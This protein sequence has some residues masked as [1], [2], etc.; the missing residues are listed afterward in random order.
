MA[1]LQRTPLPKYEK[2]TLSWQKIKENWGKSALYGIGA[3]LVFMLL[4]FLVYYIR[5]G[6]M[7]SWGF[8]KEYGL[9]MM[10]A[11]VIA[12]TL[13]LYWFGSTL[14]AAGVVGLIANSIV[15]YQE[16][17]VGQP[18]MA[19]GFVNLAILLAGFLLGV[20]LEVLAI[21]RA[22]KAA[23]RKLSENN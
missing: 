19:G 2:P 8:F 14:L 23:P 1:K 21:R 17:L 7:A 13:K 15:T 12:I 20:I 11:S 4:I 6:E 5:Y 9:F 22:K 10:A 3:G 18:T 16:S